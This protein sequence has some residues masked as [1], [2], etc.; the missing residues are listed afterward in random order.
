MTGTLAEL[1]TLV[2]QCLDNQLSRCPPISDMPERM[3]NRECWVSTCQHKPHN[4]AGRADSQD[5][6]GS[7]N[8]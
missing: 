3:K 6:K 8:N 4:M 2:E 7:H 1:R 5:V